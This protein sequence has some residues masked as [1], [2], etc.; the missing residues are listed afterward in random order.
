MAERVNERIARQ[1]AA[2]KRPAAAAPTRAPKV[3]GG[4][5]IT[6]QL[7]KN[8]FLGGERNLLRKA[9]ELVLAWEM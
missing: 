8:L 9:Q 6:Q 2:R 1:D 5:T 3:V 4:S 7:A